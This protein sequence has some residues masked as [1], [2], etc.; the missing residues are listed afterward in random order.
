[1]SILSKQEKLKHH[2]KINNMNKKRVENWKPDLLKDPE[3]KLYYVTYNTPKGESVKIK[4]VSSHEK[5]SPEFNV[6]VHK[7]AG[8]QGYKGGII[9]AV[10]LDK[11]DC[12]A[13][14]KD[15]LLQLT[16]GYCNLMNKRSKKIKGEK[17]FVVP[18]PNAP[19][20]R[21]GIGAFLES[22]KA[23]GSYKNFVARIESMDKEKKKDKKMDKQ[24]SPLSTS[25]FAMSEDGKNKTPKSYRDPHYNILYDRTNKK[26]VGTYLPKG[27]PGKQERH[28]E[29]PMDIKEYQQ[30]IRNI[31]MKHG[32]TVAGAEAAFAYF[33]PK[34]VKKAIPQK[35]EGGL[36]DKKNPT[37][38]DRKQLE[39][40][41]EIEMEHANDPDKAKEIAMDHLEEMPD[42]YTHLKGM[43]DRAKK[44]HEQKG[45]IAQQTGI[46]YEVPQDAVMKFL[47]SVAKKLNKVEI[48]G[49]TP[50]EVGGKLRRPMPLSERGYKFGRKP[51]ASGKVEPKV[52]KPETKRK[53]ETEPS[54]QIKKPTPMG[55]LANEIIET[56]R[57]KYSKVEKAKIADWKPKHPEIFGESRKK[58]KM[59]EVVTFKNPETKVAAQ[60]KI[61]DIRSGKLHLVDDA[62]DVYRV[63]EENV[64]KLDIKK[65]NEKK[66]PFEWKQEHTEQFKHGGYPFPVIENTDKLNG[67]KQ[68]GSHF[69]DTS[70][71]GREDEPAL[72]QKQFHSK[73]KPGKAYAVTGMG[74]FQAHVGEFER[75]GKKVK[76]TDEFT[77]ELKK[78]FEDHWLY[79][80]SDAFRAAAKHYNIPYNLISK[81]EGTMKYHI[82]RIGDCSVV[83][84]TMGRLIDVK[85]HSNTKEPELHK[86]LAKELYIKLQ[87]FYYNTGMRKS[88]VELE[89]KRI[90][91]GRQ[92]SVA[93]QEGLGSQQNRRRQQ[94]LRRKWRPQLGTKKPKSEGLRRLSRQQRRLM[95]AEEERKDVGK[96]KDFNSRLTSFG[97]DFV[98]AFGSKLSAP[99]TSSP[100]ITNESKIS[101][102]PKISQHSEGI[103][104]AAPKLSAPKMSSTKAPQTAAPKMSSISSKLKS[105]PLV[106]KLAARFPKIK[107]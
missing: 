75:A 17:K 40:G 93:W 105:S 28:Y 102:K 37:K 99:K 18:D 58:W 31:K 14:G 101:T 97:K 85:Y 90:L 20:K 100:K 36:A 62:G 79:N 35:I 1:L 74:K 39:M 24:D 84:K 80:I 30:G 104:I 47:K 41:I 25:G 66:E 67:W 55:N 26:V 4:M 15:F 3:G 6:Q 46:M 21:I 103:K 49:E 96:S 72:T 44:Q 76:K 22:G 42:Y 2:K 27:W 45:D 107:F 11:N 52:I 10:R 63:P 34:D 71:F 87:G 60:G 7:E 43:E 95:G 16:K 57:G 106:Q 56:Y 92:Y 54:G 53:V 89:K 77:Y 69:V 86:Q 50:P 59:G 32:Q 65:A 8:K 51:E 94:T 82:F 98:K 83:H 12:S 73:L 19:L 9:G 48:H 68:T 33:K 29:V 64:R 13:E 23:K 88:D 5:G 78:S 61:T 91:Y 38:Y 70:G 81:S